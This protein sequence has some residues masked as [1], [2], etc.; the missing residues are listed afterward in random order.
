MSFSHAHMRGACV[1]PTAAEIAARPCAQTLAVGKTTVIAAFHLRTG[2][3]M[4]VK[5]RAGKSA[6]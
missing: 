2:R 3:L 1:C 6:V 5:W 4:G